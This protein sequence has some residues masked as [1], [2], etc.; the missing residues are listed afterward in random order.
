M[1]SRGA[2]LGNTNGRTHGGRSTPEYQAWIDM[3]RRC[4]RANRDNFHNYGG[5]GIRVC[6]R[7]DSFVAFLAD[8]GA[9][10]SSQHTLERRHNNRH[11]TPKNVGWATVKEQARNRRGCIYIRY[12]G[13][14]RCIADWAEHAGIPEDTFRARLKLGWSFHRA[15]ITPVRQQANSRPYGIR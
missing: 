15:Y 7:W 3:R 1:A 11:Y 9:R 5:R 13:Q 8:V 14:V 2:Q 6:R 12:R 10:P 4:R